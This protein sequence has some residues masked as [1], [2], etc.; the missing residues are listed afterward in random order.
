MKQTLQAFYQ[1][2]SSHEKQTFW[3]GSITFTL[4]FVM[5]IYVLIPPSWQGWQETQ[6]QLVSAE[7]V[8]NGQFSGG[9]TSLMIQY[10]PE[11]GPILRGTLEIS[12]IILSTMK[13]I[14]VFYQKDEPTVF[15]VHNPTLLV[16]A[17]T[18]TIFGSCVLVAFFLY[19]RDSQRGISYD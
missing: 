18:M 7:M 11:N 5:L 4:G 6:G 1:T 14:R 2:L 13:T 17:A 15:Y 8:A 12:P 10:S 16:V 19:N 3:F 9:T